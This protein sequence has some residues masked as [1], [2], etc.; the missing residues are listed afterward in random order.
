MWGICKNLCARFSSPS[1]CLFKINYL[2][3]DAISSIGAMQRRK[4]SG[5]WPVFRHGSGLYL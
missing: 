4:G 3:G 1:L 2:K 5:D